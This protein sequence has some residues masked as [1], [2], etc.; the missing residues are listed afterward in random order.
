MNGDMYSLVLGKHPLAAELLVALDITPQSC[1]R[2]R[3]V[4]L[5]EEGDEVR[6]VVFTRNGGCNRA[7]HEDVFERLRRHPE[8]ICDW[9]DTYDGTY[10]GIEFRV[11]AKYQDQAVGVQEGIA[12]QTD[13]PRRAV[14][15]EPLQQRWERAM[16]NLGKR[17]WWGDTDE[18]REQS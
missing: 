17:P 10:A 3:D 1:G 4:Y 7:E 6:I 15:Y 14:L 12:K 8:Y 5:K 16:A 18:E 13:F 9:D 2:L 11:P